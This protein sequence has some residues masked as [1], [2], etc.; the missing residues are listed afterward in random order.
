LAS[1][2]V[3]TPADGVQ[4]ALELLDGP[5][6]VSTDHV[7]TLDQESPGASSSD[8]KREDTRVIVCRIANDLYP[9]V[10]YESRDEAQRAVARDHGRILEANYVPGR[11]FYRVLKARS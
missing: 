7:P 6:E 8:W 4:G 1:A 10:R 11:A 2:K 9:G 5:S 3:W